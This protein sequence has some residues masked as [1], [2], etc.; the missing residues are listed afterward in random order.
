MRKLLLILMLLYFFI[1][2]LAGKK[3][4]DPY[5]KTTASYL[6]QQQWFKSGFNTYKPDK[7]LLKKLGKELPKYDFLVFAGTWCPDTRLL[8]PQFYKVVNKAGVPM[9]KPDTYL[10]NGELS[11]PEGLEKEYNIYAVP[12]I[13]LLNNGK[14]V[15]RITESIT[16]S[17]EEELL[18]L[19]K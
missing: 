17:M 11:S 16:S 13:I 19:L 4:D 6:R 12:T 5:G 14:E 7:A 8:L 10:L 1:P 2:V 9:E 3:E 15:G 18:T